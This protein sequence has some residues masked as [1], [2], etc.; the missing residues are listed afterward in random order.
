MRMGNFAGGKGQPI[1]KH[2]DTAMSCAGTVVPIEMQFRMPSW[3][4]PENHVLYGV[5]INDTCRRDV[6]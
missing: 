3:V 6:R 5:H 4:D 1:V 2:R